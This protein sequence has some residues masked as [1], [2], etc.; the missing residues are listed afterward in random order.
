MPLPVATRDALTTWVAW[1]REVGA[2]LLFDAAYEAYI[3]EDLPHSIFEIPGARD[4]AIE[5]RSFSK[6][7]GFT[8]V[9]CGYVAI[10]RELTGEDASG[11]PVSL[12]ELWTRRQNTRF[13]GA[14]YVVQVGAAA[15]Y[16]EAGRAQLRANVE[17]YLENARRI[18][19]GLS[20]IGLTTHGGVNAPYVWLETPQG[21]PSWQLF[22]ELLELGVVGT[23]GAGFGACGEGFFRLSAFGHREQIDEALDRIRKGLG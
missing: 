16:S 17:Y 8:G 18:R 4:C 11:N 20:G 15:A 21:R 6:G 14:S 5:F 3:T 12:H 22:D 2:V 1:A 19:E 9:R 10:P 13:N 23:P 7:A